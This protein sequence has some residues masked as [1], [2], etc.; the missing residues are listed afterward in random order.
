TSI[1]GSWPVILLQH[2]AISEC[3]RRGRDLY[4]NITVLFSVSSCT[5]LCMALH[6][7]ASVKRTQPP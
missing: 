5:L 7:R 3:H 4:V 6:S 2:P 1:T